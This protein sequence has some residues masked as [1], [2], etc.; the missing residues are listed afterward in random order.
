M[1]YFY[2]GAPGHGKTLHALERLLEFQKTGRLVFACNVNSLDYAKTGISE[3]TP[4]QFKHWPSQLPTGSVLLVDEVYQHGMLP[5]RPPGSKVP[6]HVELLATHRHHGY[7]FIFVCQS[8]TKQ[9]DEFVHDLCDQ[10]IHVRRRFGL[11]IVYLKKFDFYERNPIKAVPTSLQRRM[12]PKKIFGLYKSTDLDTTERRIPFYVYVLALLILL[13]PLLVWWSSSTVVGRFTS[14]DKSLSSPSKLGVGANGA[15]ATVAPMPGV[16]SP[17]QKR[18]LT[19]EEYLT[20]FVPRVKSQPWSAPAYDGLNAPRSPPR[21]FCMIGGDIDTGTCTCLTEQGT[22]YILDEISLCRIIAIEGQ[23]EP[24]RDEKVDQRE[25][26]DEDTQK[27]EYTSRSRDNRLRNDGLS[28]LSETH[29]RD[30]EQ[31][32]VRGANSVPYGLIKGYGDIGVK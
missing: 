20:Q 29:P 8:P 6:S 9:V 14:E 7:D 19:T 13:V 24:Y 31:P 4:A 12:L 10:H 16:P 1:I 25:A 22:A 11:P 5:K 21:V 30:L 28:T 18:V 32:A 15:L 23:Y 26:M 2:T 17:E 3:F 27:L